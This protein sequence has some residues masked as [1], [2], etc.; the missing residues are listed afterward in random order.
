MHWN[1]NHW[2]EFKCK[3]ICIR[4]KQLNW[5]S[6]HRLELRCLNLDVSVLN[7]RSTD[8]ISFTTV[9]LYA[10]A[11]DYKIDGVWTGG[12]SRLKFGI[13]SLNSRSRI[14]FGIKSLNSRLKSRNI[15]QILTQP[16][17]GCHHFREYGC[18][19]Y[20]FTRG[21]CIPWP[22]MCP[23]DHVAWR[24]MMCKLS[25]W[26]GTW[27]LSH[28]QESRLWKPMPGDGTRPQIASSTIW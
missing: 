11:L 12:R 18:P 15:N 22:L 23:S 27:L 19:G 9:G 16:G 8:E 3:Y 4:F 28:W 20:Q 7:W 10:T 1:W 6:K 26:A 13:R 5:K 25:S 17:F 2:H 14:R 24:S 21:T